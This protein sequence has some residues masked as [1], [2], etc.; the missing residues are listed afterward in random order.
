MPADEV[1]A[2]P[3]N[4]GYIVSDPG[5]GGTSAVSQWF[6]ETAD[7]ATGEEMMRSPR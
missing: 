1:I 5:R 2:H 6:V 4:T 7:G 3:I